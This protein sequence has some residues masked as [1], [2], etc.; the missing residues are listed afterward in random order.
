MRIK[1]FCERLPAFCLK[2][3]VFSMAA[4]ALRNAAG[5][6]RDCARIANLVNEVELQTE[7]RPAH[8][9]AA[10]EVVSKGTIVH[11]AAD[12]RLELELAGGSFVRIASATTIRANDENN[13]ALTSGAILLHV[14]KDSAETQIVTPLVTTSSTGATLVFETYKFPNES[15]GEHATS[16]DRGARFRVSVLEGTVRVSQKDKGGES[17]VVDA[18]HALIGTVDKPLGDVVKFDPA[19][20]LQGD[21]LI[22]GFPALKPDLLALIGTTSGSA[23]LA[24]FFQTP[25]NGGISPITVGSLNPN[26][27]SSGSNE[28]SPNEERLTICHSGQ[29]LTLPVNAAEKHLQH[30]AHD[31]AGACH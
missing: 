24:A 27:L 9:A 18:K 10:G 23:W 21:V 16:L 29:T 3:L 22:T 19:L 11:T 12:S 5:A 15:S 6:T 31:Y 7:H 28:V 2:T 26:N 1:I 25:S 30:H 8:L 14:A 4:L 17:I 13:L 20:W